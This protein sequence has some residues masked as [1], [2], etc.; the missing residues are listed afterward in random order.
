M[1]NISQDGSKQNAWSG[2][3]EHLFA[4][5]A[6]EENEHQEQDVQQ[7]KP[8]EQDYSLEES[9]YE[10]EPFTL[11]GEALTQELAPIVIDQKDKLSPPSIAEQAQA[12]TIFPELAQKNLLDADLDLSGPVGPGE[13]YSS[14]SGT[15]TPPLTAEEQRIL[16]QFKKKKRQTSERFRYDPF[17]GKMISNRFRII[18][19]IGQG[20]MARVYKVEDIHTGKIYAAKNCPLDA[21]DEDK[22]RFDLEIDTHSRLNHK[23]IVNYIETVVLSPDLKFL[24]LENVKGISLEE[25]FQL[26]GPITQAENVWFIL[27]QICDA[28]EYAH[29]IN[30]IHRDLKSGNVILSKRANEEMEVK[31]L[32]FGVAKRKSKD[33][34]KLTKPGYSVGT[35]IYMSPEQCKGADVTAASDMYALGVLSYELISGKAPFGGNSPFEVMQAHCNPSLKPVPLTEIAANLPLVEQLERIIFKALELDPLVRIESAGEFK[36]VL[37]DWIIRAR[38]L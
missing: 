3:R 10:L 36:Q 32:D 13:T 1:P 15:A 5:K 7:E 12:E 37:N 19:V 28:L 26:H 34:L 31:I 20:N 6:R 33:V 14:F 24:V 8:D 38:N 27:S 35:P 16:D 22:Q 11:P 30:V 2:Q 4:A 25:I 23:N 17:L 9:V 21:E 18:D 29:S